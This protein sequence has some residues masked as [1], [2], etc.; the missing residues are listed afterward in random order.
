MT[1]IHLYAPYAIHSEDAAAAIELGIPPD[2]LLP[3][4]MELYSSLVETGEQT[5]SSLASYLCARNFLI[6]FWHSNCKQN[7]LSKANLSQI[8]GLVDRRLTQNLDTALL[9][10]AFEFLDRYRFINYGIIKNPEGRMLTHG[11]STVVVIGGGIAGLT[12]AR[13]LYNIFLGQQIPIPRIIVLEARQRIGGR[14]FTFP[15]HSRWNDSDI[16]SSVDLGPDAIPS[17]RSR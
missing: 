7:P 10:K 4:E 13:E 1:Q 11:P 2:A 17:I 8:H 12:A 6:R 15:L 5:A 16:W 14:I 9:E 3:E